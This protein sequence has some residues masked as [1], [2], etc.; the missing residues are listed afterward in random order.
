MDQVWTLNNSPFPFRVP[1][2]S[3]AKWREILITTPERADLALLALAPLTSGWDRL[4]GAAHTPVFPVG[5]GRDWTAVH[6]LPKLVFSWA[7]LGGAASLSLPISC[8]LLCVC[9]YLCVYGMHILS[10]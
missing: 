10:L 7:L 6:L 5:S 4:W 3:S 8:C 2:S 9:V 1:V